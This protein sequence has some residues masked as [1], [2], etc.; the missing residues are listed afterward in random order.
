MARSRTPTISSIIADLK[1]AAPG[2]RC[3]IDA[4]EVVKKYVYTEGSRRGVLTPPDETLEAVPLARQ[5]D[6]CN[7][8]DHL[9]DW[10]AGRVPDFDPGPLRTLRRHDLALTGPPSTVPNSGVILSWRPTALDWAYAAVAADDSLNWL[11]PRADGTGWGAVPPEW[12]DG[13][14]D[15]GSNTRRLLLHMRGRDRAEIDDVYE[16]VW[17]GS[18]TTDKSNAVNTA[19]SRANKFL[20]KTQSPRR[21]SREGHVICWV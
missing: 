20:G 12:R 13:W 14:E 21:L 7:L 3:A 18:Y 10:A 9:I 15:E 1:V 4:I 6:F 17:G 16:Q 19:I 8:V 5:V 2:G 11:K